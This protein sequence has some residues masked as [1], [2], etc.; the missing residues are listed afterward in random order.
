MRSDGRLPTSRV[1]RRPVDDRRQAEA[2]RSIAPA[3]MPSASRSPITSASSAASRGCSGSLPRR[4]RG[5]CARAPDRKFSGL[6]WRT[7]RMPEAA[8][9]RARADAG[10]IAVAPVSEVVA[11]LRARARVV[12]DFIGGQARGRGALAGQ[13]VQRGGEVGVERLELARGMERGEARAGLDG[14]LVERQ[15]A[16]AERQRAVERRPTSRPRCRREARRSGRS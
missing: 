5:R 2:L 3:S 9:V 14:Q 6:R 8:A 4:C 7:V 16:G 1:D 15:M 10:I 13:L 11:A 12:A